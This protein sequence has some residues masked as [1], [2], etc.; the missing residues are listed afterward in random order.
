MVEMFAVYRQMAPLYVGSLLV[1]LGLAA[2]SFSSVLLHRLPVRQS[3]VRPRSHCPHCRHTLGPLDLVPVISFV[4]NRGRCRYCR[5]PIWPAYLLLEL[6][7]ALTTGVAGA[8]AG[9]L[10]G[11]AFLFVW[12]GASAAVG[13][14]RSAARTRS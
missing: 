1:P 8:A 14:V 3:V 4:W 9:W 11:F 7:C 5:T 13:L 6:G 12:L 2:G 10:W